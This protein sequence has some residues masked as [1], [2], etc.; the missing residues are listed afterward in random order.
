MADTILILGNGFDIAMG[1]KTK[2]TDFIE[3]E[4][5]LFSNPDEELLEF[6]KVKNIRTEKYKDNLYLKF[7]NE[8]KGTLG[9]NWFNLEI[10]ISQLADAIM[11]FKENMQLLYDLSA[12]HPV[13]KSNDILKK[14]TNFSAKYFIANIFAPFY[15]EYEWKLLDRDFVLNKLNYIFIEQLNLLTELLE[16]YLSYLDYLDFEVQGINP[17]P[18]ALDSVPNLSHTYVLNFNYTNTSAYL[19]GTVEE[20]THFIHGRIDLDRKFNAMVFGIED[21]EN[22]VNSD[23][24]PYQKY[25][26]RVVKETGNYYETFFDPTLE[27][28]EDEL[29]MPYS[30]SKNII[31]FGHSVDPLDKEIF[32]KCFEL[33]KKGEY[34]YR[35][36]FTYVNEPAK[37]S[38]IKNLAIILGKEKLIELTGKRN[39]VFIKSDDKDGM[40]EVLLP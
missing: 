26:Q 38:I 6:L 39:I 40:K 23:L 11:Y 27:F 31:I 28:T 35:F 34:P 32:Q 29:C 36:V 2:Y 22:D 24:I 7:I 1:R 20:R 21:K 25:Y 30:S 16:I 15:Q 3:F 9:D 5:Q 10:M 12:I 33:S 13:R 37:R 19:F 8:N 4:K 18:T 14:E 17:K